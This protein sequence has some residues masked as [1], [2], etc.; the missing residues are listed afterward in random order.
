MMVNSLPNWLGILRKGLELAIWTGYRLQIPRKFQAQDYK[1]RFSEKRNFS[2]SY[3]LTG[4]EKIGSR[5]V[6][7]WADVGFMV[8]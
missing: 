1:S 8:R 3:D 2:Q 6:S 5:L 4:V 7:R